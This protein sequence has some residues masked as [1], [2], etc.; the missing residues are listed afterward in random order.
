MPMP[1]VDPTVK[2]CAWCGYAFETGGRG[3]PGKRQRYCSQACNAF[4]RVKQPDTREMSTTESAYLAG[5]IDGEGS[6]V[7]AIIKNGRTTWRLQVASTTPIILDWCMNVTK[8]GT[9]VRRISTNPKHADSLWWQCYS[10]NAAE[11]LRQCEKY[12]TL[13]RD[14]ALIVI[15]ELADIRAVYDRHRKE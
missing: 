15:A 14:K 9:I 7:A 8:V 12:M 1:K 5:L 10:W 13:K 2:A 6:I 11:V 4:G 3:R